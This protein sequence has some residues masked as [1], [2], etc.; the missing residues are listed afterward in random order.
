MV[1]TVIIEPIKRSREDHRQYGYRV[2]LDGNDVGHMVNHLAI[3]L[4]PCAFPM[5]T[6]RIPMRRCMVR[7]PIGVQFEE[8]DSE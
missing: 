2:F 3:E 7:G 5:L 8:D 6:L 1:D 4:E